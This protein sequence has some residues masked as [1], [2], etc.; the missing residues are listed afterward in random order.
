MCG[1]P[2]LGLVENLDVFVVC[3][4]SVS[5]ARLGTRFF[6]GETD[7]RAYVRRKKERPQYGRCMDSPLNARSRGTP[8]NH[9]KRDADGLERE[10]TLTDNER[11]SF[12]SFFR[13]TEAL[14]S[15]EERECVISAPQNRGRFTFSFS[16]G[17]E[18][19][20][21]FAP[22]FPFFLPINFRC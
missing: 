4:R 8:S 6:G 17:P 15:E 22:S 1:G 7:R 21:S 3:C 14:G 12:L 11:E 18:S 13:S 5:G 19:G 9:G 2:F 20:V 16:E 10:R